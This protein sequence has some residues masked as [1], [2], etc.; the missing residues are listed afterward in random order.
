LYR[1]NS[2]LIDAKDTKSQEQKLISSE[3]VKTQK[4]QAR[5]VI[6]LSVFGIM[7]LSSF[8]LINDLVFQKE[9]SV[10]KLVLFTDD[11]QQEKVE[12]IKDDLLTIQHDGI[13]GFTKLSV[14]D[15]NILRT[16]TTIFDINGW[17]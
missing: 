12:I 10:L 8:L 6:I 1:K 3:L 7:V 2:N 13:T 5:N 9:T 4:Q 17:K 14:E 11:F 16:H 15:E